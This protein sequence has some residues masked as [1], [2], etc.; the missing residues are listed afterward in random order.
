MIIEEWKKDISCTPVKKK[1]G[2]AIVK[3]GFKEKSIVSEQENHLIMK[4]I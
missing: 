4:V 3:I 2:A 1:A